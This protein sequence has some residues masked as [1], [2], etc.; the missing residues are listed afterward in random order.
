[1]RGRRA[2]VTGGAGGIGSAVAQELAA[3]GASVVLLDRDARQAA[4]RAAE[5]GA[6]G[7]VV[8][9]VR[10]PSEVAAA[11]ARADTIL[12]GLVDVLVNAAG[13]Y[14]I[15]PAVDLDVDEWED[16]LGIN[17]RG[18]WLASREVARRLLARSLPGSIVNISSTA[19]LIADQAEP[20]AHYSA[21][22]AGV[23]ALTRQFAAEWAPGIRVNAVCPGVI[24]TP[25]LRLM[26]DPAV[27]KDYLDTMVPL[28]RIGRPDDVARA[29]AFLA[30]D[31]AAY[32]TG[33]AL[34][35]DGGVTAL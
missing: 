13:I 31:E 10:E 2:I 9:D 4:T 7:H 29:I 32:V 19:G 22:K 35:V 3:R 5:V 1:M 8:A 25:M 21:S 17:L 23:I 28:R 12:G 33:V 6:A 20:A 27:G 15:R 34:P 30:S 14:R 26:D 18:T 11:T 24:D 16:V